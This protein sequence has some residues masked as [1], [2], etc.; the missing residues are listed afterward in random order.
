MSL[1]LSVL[2][3]IA[4][5]RVQKEIQT[6]DDLVYFLSIWWS[7]KYK[8]PCNH[9]LFLEKTIEELVIDYYIDKFISDPQSMNEEEKV[10]DDED[11]YKEQMGEEYKE[12]YDYLLDPNDTNQ[13]FPDV[14]EEF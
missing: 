9:Q 12:Q 2:K 3:M 8:L 13:Q 6:V 10:Q 4:K 14:K 11:W 1:D 5:N 7:E